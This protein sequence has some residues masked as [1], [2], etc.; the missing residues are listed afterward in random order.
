MGATPMKGGTLPITDRELA[1]ILAALLFWRKEMCPHHR[2][3]M[4]WPVA[5]LSS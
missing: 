4:A 2:A 1:T 3:V 5:Q